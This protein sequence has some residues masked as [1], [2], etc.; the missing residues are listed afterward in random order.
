MIVYPEY[1]SKIGQP[2]KIADI[3]EM[4][5]QTLAKTKC[6]N[7]SF[8]GG[9]DSSLMLYFMT[10]VF[11]KISVFTIGFPETHPDIEYSRLVV[12]SIEEK[13]G[14]V[15]HKVFVPRADEVASETE[16]KPGPDVGVRLFY[17]FL[18]EKGVSG[19]IACDGIDEYMAGYYD[20]QQQPDEETYYKY[21][22]RLRNEHLKPLDDN[23]KGVKV[24][25]PYLDE[26]LLCLLAQIPIAD[27]VDGENRKKVMVQ[28]ARGRIPDAVIDR[29]KYGFCDAL[30][31]KKAKQWK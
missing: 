19:I 6:A 9:L 20:H 12:K 28:M 15:E 2:V 27:K 7:L 29:W 14:S 17:R 10:R 16:K 24:Y 31:I 18:A 3:E 1:W 23:S 8:S 5:I 26:R 4:V 22:R 21:I 25:L 30:G 11:H 13:F